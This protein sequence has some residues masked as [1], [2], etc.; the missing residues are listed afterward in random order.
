M[1]HINCHESITLAFINGRIGDVASWVLLVPGR[2]TYSSN[3]RVHAAG[4]GSNF[5]LKEIIFLTREL[6]LILTPLTFFPLSI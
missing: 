1:S 3:G 2:P 4:S 5:L 6:S